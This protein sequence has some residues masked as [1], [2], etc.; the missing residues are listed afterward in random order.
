M[1]LT[2]DSTQSLLMPCPPLQQQ[3][4]IPVEEDLSPE[5]RAIL[6]TP[7]EEGAC[8]RD[9][10]ICCADPR[11]TA[12]LT[13]DQPVGKVLP[14]RI[15][16]AERGHLIMTPGGPSGLI[17]GLLSQVQPR[18]YYS[19]MAIMT[20]DRVELRHA[21]T[22]ED[23]LKHF[24]HHE[25]EE[26]DPGIGLQ[27]SDVPF[28]PEDLAEIPTDGFQE[29]ALL[30]GW[31]G[32]ITQSVERAYVSWHDSPK[33]EVDGKE[34]PDPAWAEF[35]PASNRHYL[36]NAVTLGP[37]TMSVQQADGS[38]KTQLVFP[39]VVKPCPRWET[40]EVR[41]A[42]D[43]IASATEALRGHYR[44]YAYT[45]ARV[46]QDPS[47]DGFVMLET[48]R[49]DESIRCAGQS[50]T[51]AT[52]ATEGMVC[53]TFIWLATE[54][55]NKIAAANNPPLPQIILDGRPRRIH[56]PEAELL[57]CQSFFR[58]YPLS[59]E[60]PP[61]TPDGL[62]FYTEAE[63]RRA[64]KWLFERLKSDIKKEV[65]NSADLQAK[66]D[67]L[68][69]ESG[70][71][72]SLWSILKLLATFSVPQ[73][74]ILLNVAPSVI[75]KL[76]TFLTDMPED[77]ANQMGNAF[78]NDDC[79]WTAK[80]KDTW[81]KQPGTGTTVSP[82]DIINFWAPPTYEDQ[83]VVHGLY[84]YNQ[85]IRL[86]PPSFEKNAPPPSIWKLSQGVGDM[87]GRVTFLGLGVPNARIRVGCSKYLSG[88]DGYYG[89]GHVPEGLYW[90][91][92]SY[93]HPQT[94]LHLKAR[95][96]P[97]Q[98]PLFGSAYV[99]FELE[100]PP[101]T[102]R[103]VIVAA[104]MDLVNRYAIGED[105]WGHPDCEPEVVYLG[106]DMFPPDNPA[107]DEIRQKSLRGKVGKS[108]QVDDWGQA[109][110][111]CD[112]EI[113]PDRSIKFVCR[114]RLKEDADDDWQHE[115]TFVVAPKVLETD[116]SYTH[117]IDLVRSEDAWPVRAH[118]VLTIDNNRL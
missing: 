98:V 12:Q 56:R 14:W 71:L 43:R 113:Q 105:W 55:A 92:A 39:L 103:E 41:K 115:D 40:E 49:P 26:G 2:K 50:R 6:G 7:A 57:G 48:M 61:G 101:D 17:G 110:F 91:E 114:A 46:G 47:K 62:Y 79:Y 34:V 80:D 51:T 19:H 99:D 65:A 58:R 1:K 16:N 30:N 107:F 25:G 11:V 116:P 32:T 59:D 85:R 118:I 87:G 31:P 38:E 5:V 18:Q 13:N 90:A 22:S 63:R 111:E 106:L 67:A 64:A 70:T 10:P 28:I 100:E 68:M 94:K 102:R 84:G 42:L 35:D 89:L 27:L 117:V 52:L 24:P 96:R 77:V 20:R 60:I 109:Q 9:Q 21:T 88:T 3:G 97:V 74:A 112:L 15:D 75:E 37:V 4:A 76:V 45:D 95:G 93:F 83:Q 86:L 66:V 82:D 108:E 33:I 36:I 78:A 72:W 8:T 29:A 54:I 104:H 69:A 81:R 73:V 23:R 44:L 53:S